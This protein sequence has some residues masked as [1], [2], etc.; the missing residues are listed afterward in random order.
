MP[1]YNEVR[2]ETDC[3]VKKLDTTVVLVF[4]G[5]PSDSRVVVYSISS[6]LGI[7]CSGIIIACRD[8]MWLPF[9]VTVFLLCTAWLADV[10]A[11][12]RA[13]RTCVVAGGTCGDRKAEGAWKGHDSLSIQHYTTISKTSYIY[14]RC[15]VM[16]PFSSSRAKNSNNNLEEAAMKKLNAARVSCRS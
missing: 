16:N 10:D 5:V 11:A 15:E 13:H 14:I 1:D 2:C 6:L 7:S 12:T 8:S 9:S 4:S 3:R